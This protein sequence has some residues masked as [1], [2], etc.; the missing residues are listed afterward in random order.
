MQS[1]GH[2]SIKGKIYGALAADHRTASPL[3]FYYATP[4]PTD[5]PENRPFASIDDVCYVGT[6]APSN[7]GCR[8]KPLTDPAPAPRP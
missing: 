3:T 2:W 6:P 8:I 7:T 1:D 4:W 5:T